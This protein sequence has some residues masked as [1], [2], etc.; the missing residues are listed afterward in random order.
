MGNSQKVLVKFR[1]YVKPVVFTVPSGHADDLTHIP[2]VEWITT[3]DGSTFH[4][5]VVPEV[6]EPVVN[7]AFVSEAARER[8]L[9][10]LRYGNPDLPY[11]SQ[12]PSKI[13]AIKLVRDETHCTLKQAKDYVDRLCNEVNPHYPSSFDP[14]SWDYEPEPPF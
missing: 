5:G 2:D 4:Y 12:H 1:Y 10:L 9:T 3:T 7:L 13:Q 8:I 14:F 11:D 6:P